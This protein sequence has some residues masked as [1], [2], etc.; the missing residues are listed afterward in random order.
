MYLLS[1]GDTPQTY[2]RFLQLALKIA[3][4]W[5]YCMLA[6]NAV[7]TGA[8]LGKIMCVLLPQS[9]DC[10]IK[11]LIVYLEVMSLVKLIGQYPRPIA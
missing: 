2:N 8:I 11:K 6:I 1:H 5:G 3:V 9:F 4:V 10:T 7:L